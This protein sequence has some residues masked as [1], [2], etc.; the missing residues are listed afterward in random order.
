[1]APALRYRLGVVLMALLNGTSIEAW[2]RISGFSV[3]VSNR[4]IMSP[5]AVPSAQPLV[6]ILR[7]IFASKSVSRSVRTM[8]TP[9]S[10]SWSIPVTTSSS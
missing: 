9:S 10:S 3:M 2:S 1:M 8:T 6:R 5:Y 7:F 4:S